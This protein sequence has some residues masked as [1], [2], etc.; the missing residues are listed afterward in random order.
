MSTPN[1]TTTD[2][3]GTVTPPP[4]PVPGT[5]SIIA[6]VVAPLVDVPSAIL[7]PTGP[8]DWAPEKHR[9]MK[10][11]GSL[12]E[13]ATARKVADAYRGL[14]TKLGA[15]ASV[16]APATVADYK[17][18]PA[19]GVDPA[20][21]EAFAKD[22]LAQ[23]FLGEAHKLGMT[24]AQANL[25]VNRY[26]S[27]IP[28]LGLAQANATFAEGMT[29]LGKLYGDEAG[30]KAAAATVPRAIAAFSSGPDLPGS[31]DAL[32]AKFGSDPDFIAFAAN[33]AKEIGEDKVPRVDASSNEADV[34]TLMRSKP[35]WDKSDPMHAQTKARVQGFYDRQFG[36]ARK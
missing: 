13:S 18:A 5:E 25:V 20:T 30:V 9:V 11:D 23:E 3:S 21:F 24:D 7:P 10:A 36:A 12:D 31:A 4:A 16:L 35:Y 32:Y 33:V 14:E 1:P 6:P 29:A 34:Q 22:P 15:G 17:L 26:L 2:T 19:E 27:L 8:N 28:E